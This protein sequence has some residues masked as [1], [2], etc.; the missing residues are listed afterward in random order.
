MRLAHGIIVLGS[1]TI[2]FSSLARAEV[3]D[4][5]PLMEKL[6][7][8]S[9]V[10]E[11]LSLIKELKPIALEPQVLSRIILSA[12][13][14][15]SKSEGHP[16]VYSPIAV[17][18]N[19]AE[20]SAPSILGKD[21]EVYITLEPS[22]SAAKEATMSFIIRGG[23]PNVVDLSATA[24]SQILFKLNKKGELLEAE[25]FGRADLLLKNLSSQLVRDIDQDFIIEGQSDPEDVL[26][27]VESV[28]ASLL[29]KMIKDPK[30]A[31]LFSPIP[32]WVP[33]T[34]D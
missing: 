27:L 28:T 32:R 8:A 9:T 34:K 11:R 18:P 30:P 25:I 14:T 10:D 17:E 1:V 22:A 33:F 31:V 4:L 23:R 6:R 29:E 20:A 26:M 24:G 12:R 21:P 7:N 3:Q 13:Q 2:L 15:K 5:S 19:G 16:V